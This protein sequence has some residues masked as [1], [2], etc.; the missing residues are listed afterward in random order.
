[1]YETVF[2]GLGLVVDARVDWPEAL[3]RDWRE[4]VLDDRVG[5]RRFEPVDDPPDVLASGDALVKVLAC[6]GLD[7]VRDA[8]AHHAVEP[9]AILGGDNELP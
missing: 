8:D 3:P 9:V 4:W 5:L 1:M 6:A 2:L 7:P